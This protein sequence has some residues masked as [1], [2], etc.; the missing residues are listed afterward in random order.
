[1][2]INLDPALKEEY[3]NL[4]QTCQIQ[5]DRTSVIDAKINSIVV[6]KAKYKTVERKSNVP[7]YVIA[8]IHSLESDLNF[9]THLHN[10]DPLTDRT[11]HIPLGR[12]REGDP[13][14]SWE[15]SAIDALEYDG[16]STW[17]DWSIEGTCFSFEKYNGWG[18]RM[19]HPQ[20]KSPYLW[21]FSNHYQK[22]KYGRDGKFDPELVSEQCGAMVLAKRME[23]RGLISLKGSPSTMPLFNPSSQVTWL[24]L[25]RQEKG[26]K[27]LAVLTALAGNKVTHVVELENREVDELIAFCGRYPN[28][29]TFHIAA[30]SKAVPAATELLMP[31]ST[32]TLP[33]LSRILRWGDKGDDVKALQKALNHL[34]FNAGA[35]DGEIGDQTEGA[36]KAFQFNQGLLIDGEV[37]PITWEK[38]GG[39]W[40]EGS[41]II[42]ESDPI[43]EKLATFAANEASK[44]LRW[45]G[46]GSE[47]EKYLKPLRQIM[48]DLGHI[49]SEPVFYNWCAAFVTY[50]CRQVGIDVPDKP[51]GF[52]ASMALVASWESWAEQKGYWFLP[53]ST[54]PMRGD[55][56]TFD[57]P[58]KD[59]K[60]DHIGIVR[61]YT[62]GGS[63]VETAEG[64]AGSD[65]NQSGHF[66]RKLSS[67]SGI[68][69]IR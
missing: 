41:I 45:N 58:G 37:G 53:S 9:S 25:Y 61:G 21:S 64:N 69:R 51:D 27:V 57:W 52:W 4:Y 36:V 50:C 66:S 15:A 44:K 60:F 32:S 8:I 6:N 34:G 48:Q 19:Y 12:P 18:Y 7:W 17:N 62:P 29:K 33:P 20:V 3:K 22:G 67:I 46:E 39:E 16:L 65:S 31:P 42:N 68:V 43:A 54:K 35:E 63:V 24:E 1:M 2:A 56:L 11:V 40:K 30:S 26:D 5:P 47:A 38:L 55:I 10:G 13:P 14:F 23:E 49:G 59:G 28:A